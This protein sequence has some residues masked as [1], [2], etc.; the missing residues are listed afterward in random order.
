MKKK[1]KKK[2][3]KKNLLLKPTLAKNFLPYISIPT[4]FYLHCTS[5]RWSFSGTGTSLFF[6]VVIKVPLIACRTIHHQHM[7]FLHIPRNFPSQ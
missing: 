5:Q 3:K 1:K 6:V 7:V 2:M 4:S